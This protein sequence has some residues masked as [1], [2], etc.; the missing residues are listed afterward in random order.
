[1][2]NL[3]LLEAVLYL[4]MFSHQYCNFIGQKKLLSK[5]ELNQNT[6]AC[7]GQ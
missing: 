2:L 1:M 5:H 7:T 3:L 6:M 4:Y